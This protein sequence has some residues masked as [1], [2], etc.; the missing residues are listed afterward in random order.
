MTILLQKNRKYISNKKAF[1]IVLF[2][3]APMA[4][5]IRYPLNGELIVDGIDGLTNVMGRSL[6]IQGLVSGEFPL[7]NKF[8]ANGIP[9]FSLNIPTFFLGW[10]PIQWSIF[11]LICLHVF[12]AAFFMYLYL[13]EIK[14]DSIAALA[15]A[16]MLL[17]SIHLG[18]L[19]K[20]HPGIIVASSIFPVVMYFVQRYLNTR[21]MKY[22]A[23]AAGVLAYG[24]YSS[25]TQYVSYM[26]TASGIYL[27]AVSMKNK[28]RIDEVIKALA[29]F[30]ILC[31]QR[32][33]CIH[34]TRGERDRRR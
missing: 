26:A 29:V 17:F 34:G 32:G 3:I 25:N 20:M 30:A 1:I 4:L 2:I 10:M 19:R 7:W 27:F 23:L 11:F 18:G 15:V 16:V 13:I 6:L 21:K 12:F 9:A 24:F 14:C 28:V 8:L 31:R 33:C 5:L 22:T